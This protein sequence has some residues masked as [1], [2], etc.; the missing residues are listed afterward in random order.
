VKIFDRN[1]T[2]DW[3]HQ[4]ERDHEQEHCRMAKHLPVSVI[5][6]GCFLSICNERGR[7]HGAVI[8]VSLFFSFTCFSDRANLK[9]NRLYASGV[10]LVNPQRERNIQKNG[11]A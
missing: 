9:K 10:R 3:L 6:A 1:K 4:Q 2:A 5:P 11:F 7:L 8:V